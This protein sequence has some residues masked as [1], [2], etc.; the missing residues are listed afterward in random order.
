VSLGHVL[1]QTLI[2]LMILFGAGLFDLYR[3]EM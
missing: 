2:Y 3:K 1:L